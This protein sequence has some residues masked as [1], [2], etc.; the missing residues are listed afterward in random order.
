MRRNLFAA[1]SGFD[2]VM[3]ASGHEHSLQYIKYNKQDF[4]VT[5]AS[6]RTDWVGTNQRAGFTYSQA[7]LVRLTLLENGELWMDILVPD[8]SIA[9]GR[10]VF[11]KRLKDNTYGK[12]DDST[13]LKSYVSLA[14]S[15]IVLPAN[16]NLAA[17]S[18]REFFFGKH[19]RTAW[20]VPVEV[21]VFDLSTAEGGLTI[22]KKGGGFQ[23]Q[24]LQ[25]RNSK[26]EEFTLRS[27]TKYTERILGPAM[28][29]T[30]AAEKSFQLALFPGPK[31]PLDVSARGNIFYNANHCALLRALSPKKKAAAKA[32]RRPAK[33]KKAAKKKAA[34]RMRR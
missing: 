5:N 7:G 27:V 32:A 6:V 9:E 14:D 25:L 16:E 1:F 28:Q 12:P 19:H 23:T 13:A 15:T 31:Q 8:D 2:N 22:V 29:N 20:T 3:Y 4:I 11:R 17:G 30:F 24:S 33:K 21:P 18:F 26:G 34:R 10:L